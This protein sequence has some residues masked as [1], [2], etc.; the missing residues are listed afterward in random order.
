MEQ[1][2]GCLDDFVLKAILE[3]LENGQDHLL[4]ELRCFGTRLRTIID[5]LLRDKFCCT[6]GVSISGTI[7]APS[8]TVYTSCRLCNFYHRYSLVANE[9]LS[10]IALRFKT[11]VSTLRR[12]NNIITD[13]TLAS[14]NEIYIPGTSPIL[15]YCCPAS[16]SVFTLNITTFFAN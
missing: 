1:P 9:S 5:A 14:R 13:H 4:I 16:S 12:V 8:P 3:H 6:W 10:S 7:L 2:E 11:D 15:F